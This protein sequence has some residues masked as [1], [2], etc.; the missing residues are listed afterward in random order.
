[1]PLTPDEL[2]TLRGELRAT[3]LTEAEIAKVLTPAPAPPPNRFEAIRAEVQRQMDA[4]MEAER[5]RLEY[6]RRLGGS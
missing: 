1:M 5:A 3:G 6:L 4:A 2:T